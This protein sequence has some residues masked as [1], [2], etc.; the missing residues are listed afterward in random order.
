MSWRPLAEFSDPSVPKLNNLRRAE[1]A[2]IRVP[3]TVWIEADRA[4][5][6]TGLPMDLGPAPWIIRSGSPTEDTHTTSNAGQLL[7]LVVR[8][9]STFTDTLRQV[10]DALP[11]DHSGRRLGAVF[12]QPWLRADEA[13]VA[14]CDDFYFERTVAR[15]G[16]EALTSGQERGEV[17]WGTLGDRSPWSQWLAKVCAVF[18]SD[19]RIDIEFACDADGYVLLQ[20]RPALFPIRRNPLLSLTN[21]KE[22]LGDPPSP[23]IVSVLIESGRDLSFMSIPDPAIREWDESYAVELAG[24]A[25]MNLSYWFRWM[26]HF[27]LPRSMVTRNFGGLAIPDDSGMRWRRLIPSVPALLRFQFACLKEVPILPRRLNE[28]DRTIYRAHD[29]AELHA[30]MVAGLSLALRA[31]FSINAM[32]SGVLI[33]RRLLRIRGEARIVTREMMEEYRQLGSLP[34][35]ERPGALDRWLTRYGHRGPLESDPMRPR[36]AELRD[37]LLNDLTQAE[38]TPIVAPSTSRWSRLT[39]PFFRLEERREWFR[40]SL[41]KR[42]QTMRIKILAEA[43]RLCSRG[44]L[45]APTDAFWLRGDDL[46]SARPLAE[47]VAANRAQFESIKDLDLPI[48]GTRDE[49]QRLIKAGTSERSSNENDQQEFTGIPL[50]SARFEGVVR[51]ADDLT[52]LLVDGGLNGETVLVVPTLEPSWAVVFPRV[53]AVIAEVGGEMSHASILLREAR[54]PALVNCTGIYRRVRT[55]TRVRLDGEAGAVHI[56]P[57]RAT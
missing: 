21:H 17:T 16:N 24:R 13:G 6:G 29:L 47:A 19:R 15:G 22:I 32:L 27:G 43:E 12:V 36:F 28:L 53:G 40:D 56:L 31:N 41:M 51:K 55:G 11:A 50:S 3:R 49:L 2:G 9:E 14:F 54:K 10:V 30:A 42:W 18:K 20:A 37:V 7:S 8:E 1:R 46:K 57:E 33:V 25:W 48:T 45:H 34:V 44:E 5:G 4:S 35:D 38:A 39:E 23:W 52:K 26:D